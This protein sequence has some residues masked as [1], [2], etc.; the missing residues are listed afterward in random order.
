MDPRTKAAGN[1][2]DRRERIVDFV[3]DHPDKPLQGIALLLAQGNAHV[4]EH[5]QRVRDAVLAKTGSPH[6][7]VHRIAL[8]GKNQ[9]SPIGLIEQLG[10]LQI[11]GARGPGLAPR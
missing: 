3:T 10:K 7:P 9:D 11:I 5:Q 8:A 6:H 2:L 4:R 1:G